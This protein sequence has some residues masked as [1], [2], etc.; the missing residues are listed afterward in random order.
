MDLPNLFDVDLSELTDYPPKFSIFAHPTHKATESV[1]PQLVVEG[2]DVECSFKIIIPSECIP[3]GSVRI[4]WARVL[5]QG[6]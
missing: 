6:R 1:T 4:I 2:L 5:E 3:A